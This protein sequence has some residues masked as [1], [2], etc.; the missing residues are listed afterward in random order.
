MERISTALLAASVLGV[1]YAPFDP[2]DYTAI[3]RRERSYQRGSNQERR[4]KQ[5][6]IHRSHNRVQRGRCR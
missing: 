3:P 4:R 1:T 5:A 6:R 2:L